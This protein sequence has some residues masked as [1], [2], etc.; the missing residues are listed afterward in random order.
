MRPAAR[1]AHRRRVW[2]SAGWV[3]ALAVF[4]FAVTFAVGHGDV[5]GAGTI[6]PAGVVHHASVA[7]EQHRD[8]DSP[9]AHELRAPPASRWRASAF[10][11]LVLGV[12]V[13]ALTRR[14]LL[15]GAQF[16][17]RAFRFPGLQPGRGPPLLRIA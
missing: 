2:R 10:A 9:I 13:A 5:P 7:L 11:I 12:F 1:P 17:I 16:R 3:A 4:A 14:H 8:T 6:S 15:A